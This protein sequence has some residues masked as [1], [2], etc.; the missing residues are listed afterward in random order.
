MIVSLNW[1]KNYVEI[2]S[3]YS[4]AELAELITLHSCEV[5]QVIDQKAQFDKIISAKIVKIEKHPDAD[6]LRLP[7]VD[8]G[9]EKI[10]VVCGAP[11]I[12]VGQIIPLAQEGA[13][14]QHDG[15]YFEIK[16]AKIRGV[17]SCGMLCS[18]RELGLSEDHSGILILP[19]DTAL[20]K[21]FAEVYGLDDVLIEIDNK[22]MTHRPDLWGY[23]GMA[24]EF[25]AVLKTKFKPPVFK[26]LKSS[27]AELKFKVRVEAPKLCPRY[28][29]VA[30]RKVK[31]S[32]SPAYIQTRLRAA[33]LRPINNIVD[34]TNYV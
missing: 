16:K 32:D 3:K 25:A 11:N 24:R 28:M 23:V 5:E 1:L 34:V 4:S 10:T 8:T 15:E 12:E 33:G 27:K 14:V 18:G 13:R 21:N 17:E 22:S 9:K 2:P 20:G 30:L 31:I 6:K 7:T 19:P 29:G 26:D